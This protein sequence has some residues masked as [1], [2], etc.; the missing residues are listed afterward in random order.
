M[1]AMRNH[2]VAQF[3][4]KEGADEKDLRN[5]MSPA[6]FDLA[7]KAGPKDSKP[8]ANKFDYKTFVSDFQQ[9]VL[10][11]GK[12]LSRQN[13]EGRNE[14]VPLSYPSNEE[15]NNM[16]VGLFGKALQNTCETVI[17]QEKDQEKPKSGKDA[18]NTKK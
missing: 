5:Y 4:S 9:Q 7:E 17:T 11:V 3:H 16:F 15:A 2:K 18:L 10:G 1:C 13:A 6:N 12:G 8:D 14:T